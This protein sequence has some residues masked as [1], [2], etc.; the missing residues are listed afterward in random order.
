[1][2]CAARSTQS[3]TIC[4]GGGMAQSRQRHYSSSPAL[5]GG[6]EPGRDI[7]EEL[8][9][10]TSRD[11]VVESDD[12]DWHRGD[13]GNGE[14]ELARQTARY[15]LGGYGGD[16][17]DDAYSG[18]RTRAH[19]PARE[20]GPGRMRSGRS[21][22]TRDMNRG[23]TA[24]GSFGDPRDASQFRRGAA[25]YRG[26]P[27]GYR[28]HSNAWDDQPARRG[29]RDGG[30]QG[31]GMRRDAEPRGGYGYPGAREYTQRWDSEAGDY[32][33]GQLGGSAL[34]RTLRGPKGYQRSDERLRE[35]ICERLIQ[36]GSAIDLS[37]VTVEVKEGKVELQGWVP[38][39]RMKH[40]IEDVADECSGV[41]DIDNRIRVGAP[42]ETGAEEGT[43]D[44]RSASAPDAVTE[45]TP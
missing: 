33:V 12:A 43:A 35:D 17:E 4:E 25:A 23:A 21:D 31:R 34:R 3:I 5:Y 42:A 29:Y 11:S 36:R 8:G 38:E 18:Y 16:Y 44:S 41:K 13:G 24:P 32:G 22:P 9:G 7:E 27:Y 40:M 15:P 20:D 37:D 1:M 10:S 6:L 26:E 30:S 2:R 39:R 14:A 19:D 28:P 45:K